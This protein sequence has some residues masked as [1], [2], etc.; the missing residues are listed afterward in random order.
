MVSVRKPV[1]PQYL[2]IPEYSNLWEIASDIDKCKK[3]YLRDSAHILYR[4][5]PYARIALVGQCPGKMEVVQG[6]PWCGPAGHELNKAFDSVGLITEEDVFITNIVKARPAAPEGSGRENYDPNVEATKICSRFIKRE[7]SALYNLQVIILAGKIAAVGMDVA[8]Q[9]EPM[10]KIAG[11]VR[12]IN[13]DG[14]DIPAIP[15]YHTAA[16]LHSKDIDQV[17]KMKWSIHNSLKLVKKLAF[18]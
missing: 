18:E 12:S 5:N 9:Q 13:V 17:R 7:L 11:K 1:A 4:G 14:R 10:Y 2:R 16:C 8:D 3:C 6:I 15:I